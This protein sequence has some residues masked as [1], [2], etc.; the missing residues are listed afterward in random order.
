MTFSAKAEDIIDVMLKITT[1][2]TGFSRNIPEIATNL[3]EKKNT[4]MKIQ[5]CVDKLYDYFTISNILTKDEK[6]KLRNKKIQIKQLK[7]YMFLIY[8]CFF[9]LN[10]IMLI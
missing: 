9:Q 2:Y 3:E 4:I 6:I 1:D 7:T 8:Q 5:T 10:Y